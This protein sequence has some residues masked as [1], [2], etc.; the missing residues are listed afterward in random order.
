MCS[1][2]YV[3]VAICKLL[4]FRL[5]LGPAGRTRRSWWQA[6]N[7]TR[8]L[9]R[10]TSCEQM[11]VA[12]N[13]GRLDMKSVSASA[14]KRNAPTGLNSEFQPR[15]SALPSSWGQP[16]FNFAG[17]SW[18]GAT[19]RIDLI[20]TIKPKKSHSDHHSEHTTN[21]ARH[22]AINYFLSLSF[23]LQPMTFR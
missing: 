8:A 9:G 21:T 20:I 5:G 14:Q 23:G 6:K 13:F 18:L 22:D 10:H 3:F 17:L 12:N 1:S 11:R 15:V 19:L 16:A 4:Q 2:C 7:W